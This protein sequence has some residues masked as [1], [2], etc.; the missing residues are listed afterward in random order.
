MWAQLHGLVD[1][2]LQGRLPADADTEATWN[3]VIAGIELLKK[4]QQPQR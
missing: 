2:E 1:L 4:S 3:Q